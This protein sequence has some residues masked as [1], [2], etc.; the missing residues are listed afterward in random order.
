VK[1]LN[2]LR[3]SGMGSYEKKEAILKEGETNYTG[4]PPRHNIRE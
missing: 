2:K 3:Q 4:L 1:L